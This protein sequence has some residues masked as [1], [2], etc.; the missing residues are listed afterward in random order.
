MKQIKNIL[1]LLVLI[2]PLFMQAADKKVLEQLQALPGVSDVQELKSTAYE[3]KYLLNITQE[4]DPIHHQAG[5]FKQRVI[6]CHVGYDRPTVL[7]TE[8]YE[9]NYALNENYREELSKL[10]NA[11]VVFVEYRYFDASTPSPCNWDYLTVENSLY[12]L[13][14]VNQ[15][16]R[17]MYKGKWIS[18][19]ISK[20]GQTCMFYR[21]FFPDDVD[22]S[23]P[24]VAPLNK[25]VED[26]RHEPFI[27]HQVST[28][29]KRQH[30]K[31]FQI[32]VL[33]RKAAFMPLFTKFCT[34]KGYTFRVPLE[35][36]YDY[37]VLEYSFAIWQWGT[38]MS[39]IP[40]A[41]ASDKE[42]FDHFIKT[43]DPN[44]FSTQTPYLSFNVQAARELGYYGYD[45]KP[46][47]K[48]L[49]I[50]TAKDYMHRVMLPEQFANLKF[51]KTLY[52][53][54]I[55]WLKNNDRKMVY[56]Y[57]GIDP[58]GSSGVAGLSFLKKK[59]LI[60]VYVLP[61]G[62]HATRINSF[63]EP[64]RTEIIN[65]IKKYLDITAE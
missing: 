24:Y 52:N 29:D 9:C 13:H 40:N 22:V 15:T 39:K 42:I 61:E 12:D 34:E 18:T 62:S 27:D 23:V 46:F 38:P 20:G 47:K 31:D 35:E 3:N 59:D 19:G 48:W 56:I 37:C 7:V 43:T 58:W 49:T 53:K 21:V 45:T 16:F 14:H 10:L 4:V 54:T 44:Y 8:G 5:S 2:F 30:V 6:V 11:N 33:K 51:D 26:G 55:N 36:I 25:S 60:K 63:P 64:T 41:S 1:F 17:Q 57:G 32:E 28:A 50:K 65:L